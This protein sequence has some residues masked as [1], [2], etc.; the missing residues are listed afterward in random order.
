MVTSPP[1]AG[2][3]PRRLRPTAWNGLLERLVVVLVPVRTRLG[4]IAEG[5][6]RRVLERSRAA[7]AETARVLIAISLPVV[8]FAHRASASLC[9]PSPGVIA[10]AE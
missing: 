6:I 5:M 7:S 10:C 2:M 4:E 9:S 1:L 8:L 3:C